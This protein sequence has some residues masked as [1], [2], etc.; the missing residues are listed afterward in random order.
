[1]IRIGSDFIAAN[2]IEQTEQSDSATEQ[3]RKASY[4]TKNRHFF[5][6]SAF[7][8]NGLRAWRYGR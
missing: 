4:S 6:H 3:Q 8:I 7:F 1:V 2:V 5:A